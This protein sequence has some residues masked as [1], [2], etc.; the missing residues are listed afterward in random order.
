MKRI[1]LTTIFL[2]ALAVQGHAVLKEKDL[3]HTLSI[4]REELTNYYRELEQQSELMKQQREAVGKNI[5]TV[6][7]KSNQNALMLYSQKP[8]YIFDLTYA[9]HE[10]T[11]Q[12]HEFKRTV[13]PFNTFVART[14][15]EIA[16]YDSLVTALS[17]MHVA[18]ARK[19]R[20]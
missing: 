5:F 2:L 10:A 9:C 20:P 11:E 19:D 18:G 8:D 16:R 6:L 17:H 12:Y 3:P 14:E 15:S 7:S 13:L 4:L 1:L